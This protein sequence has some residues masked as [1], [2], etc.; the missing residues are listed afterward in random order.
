[1]LRNGFTFH[2]TNCSIQ[3][4]GVDV[5]LDDVQT[6]KHLDGIQFF[7]WEDSD[8]GTPKAE[9]RDDGVV[10]VKDLDDG[11]AITITLDARRRVWR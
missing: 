7:L 9:W 10:T 2:P 6:G 4:F 3:Q 5:S 8:F 1:V 11:H